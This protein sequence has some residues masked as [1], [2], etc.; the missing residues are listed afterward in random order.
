VGGAAGLGEAGSDGGAPARMDPC[1][2]LTC[3]SGWAPA[4]DPLSPCCPI[5]KPVKCAGLACP[6]QTCL[7]GHHPVFNESQCCLACVV[8]PNVCDDQKAQFTQLVGTLRDQFG[9]PCQTDAECTYT[10]WNNACSSSCFVP[11]TK[12]GV[13]M[14]N[15]QLHASDT[16]CNAI[17][18]T[19]QPISCASMT[20]VCAQGRCA[21]KP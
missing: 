9:G 18:G 8:D 17:C 12:A 15:A 1:P 11:V 3:Q 14:F 16:A 20:A 21:A 19:A 10:S 5:C 7:V 13:A 4:S 6:A 2:A